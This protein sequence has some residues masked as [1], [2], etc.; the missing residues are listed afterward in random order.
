MSRMI[1]VNESRLVGQINY[2][3]NLEPRFH[4]HEANKNEAIAALNWVFIEGL[5]G[6]TG[7]LVNRDRLEAE[8]SWLDHQIDINDR[9]QQYELSAKYAVRED[10]ISWVI[11]S[12]S[13]TTHPS[14]IS[15]DKRYLEE[16]EYYDQETNEWK[17]KRT[18]LPIK[19]FPGV[20]SWSTL[21]REDWRAWEESGGPN[22]VFQRKQKIEE[23][24]EFDDFHTD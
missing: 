21:T 16:G 3:T 22:P 12:I 9:A 18:G 1:I 13:E 14:E 23:K 24:G 20:A 15:K 19:S 2:L 8:L 4:E 11:K 7:L 10:Q 17:S 5:P 6:I